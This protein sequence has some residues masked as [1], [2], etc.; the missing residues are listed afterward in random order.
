MSD[1]DLSG[2]NDWRVVARE[3]WGVE[4]ALVAD[5]NVRGTIAIPYLRDLA[6]DE[7]VT[8]MEDLPPVGETVRAAT[9]VESADGA[10]H[11]TARASDL[12][13]RR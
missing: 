13:E 5:P 10:I 9:Q 2:V 1:V 7:Q 12:S 3:S 8:G 11:L 6:P 4:V